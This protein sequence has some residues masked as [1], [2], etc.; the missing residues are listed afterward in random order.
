MVETV[1]FIDRCV[2]ATVSGRFRYLLFRS[3]C[4]S[5]D[6]HSTNLNLQHYLQF[7]VLRT[8]AVYQV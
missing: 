1:T 2:Y 7:L 6:V 3:F 5:F 8:K 4:F